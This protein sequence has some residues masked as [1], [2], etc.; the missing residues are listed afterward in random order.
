MMTEYDEWPN[1]ASRIG[2]LE[3]RIRDLERDR[4]SFFKTGILVLGAAVVGL[5]TYIWSIQIG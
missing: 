3:R 1:D 2:D 5:V 4:K